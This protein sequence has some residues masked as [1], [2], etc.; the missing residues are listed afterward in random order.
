MSDTR[1]LRQD[2]NQTH[3]ARKVRR[4]RYTRHR[5]RLRANRISLPKREQSKELA[6]VRRAVKIAGL[7]YLFEFI[8]SSFAHHQV[9]QMPNLMDRDSHQQP[10]M[11]ESGPL[12][13]FTSSSGDGFLALPLRPCNVCGGIVSCQEASETR[14]EG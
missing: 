11:V 6:L 13:G 8:Q 2:L 9:V 3:C 5:R 1:P 4:P 7:V 10:R 14:G 12:H